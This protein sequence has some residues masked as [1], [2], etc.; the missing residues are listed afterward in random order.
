LLIVGKASDQWIDAPT[1]VG[2]LTTDESASA[3]VSVKP[4]ITSEAVALLGY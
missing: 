2:T 3:P 1:T 4:S